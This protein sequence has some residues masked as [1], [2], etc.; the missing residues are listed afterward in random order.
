M[1]SPRCRPCSCEGTVLSGVRGNME[2]WTSLQSLESSSAPASDIGLTI[3]MWAICAAGIVSLVIIGAGFAPVV[4]LASLGWFVWLA[5]WRP[6]RRDRRPG[7]SSSATSSA[8][9]H[10][11]RRRRR[12]RHPL[13]ARSCA[14]ATR[15][16][17]RVGRSRSR[18]ASALRDSLRVV[19]RPAPTGATSPR[20]VREGGTARPGD[21]ADS[22]S[23]APRRSSAASSSDATARASAAT[24]R[25]AP[26]SRR[27][28][29]SSRRVSGAGRERRG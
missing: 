7:S 25:H 5:F 2:A 6:Q 21:V 13:R 20:S 11:V 23:G 17:S 19:A 26:W 9:R 12:R 22:A 3:V 8:R 27:D 16:Y 24:G 14:R 10:P 29:C 28:R 15:S 4:L 1:A 18:R